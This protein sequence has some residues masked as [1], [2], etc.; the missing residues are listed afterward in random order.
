MATTKF[1][2]RVDFNESVVSE[3]KKKILLQCQRVLDSQVVK[4]SNFYCPLD[5]SML[6]KSAIEH[7][8][9]GSGL[10]VWQTPYADAQYYGCPNKSHEKNPNATTKWFETAKARKSQEWEKLVKDEYNKYN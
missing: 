7:T 8:V 9:I 5:T 2:I 10:V 6:Q 1:D 4:D 3:T